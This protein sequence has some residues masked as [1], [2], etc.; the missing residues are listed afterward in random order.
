MAKP[1]SRRAPSGGTSATSSNVLAAPTW[2]DMRQVFYPTPRLDRISSEV[3]EVMQSAYLACKPCTRVECKRVFHVVSA[4]EAAQL[5]RRAQLI[6][7]S[8]PLS[9]ACVGISGNGK[10]LAT[11]FIF[12]RKRESG[13]GSKEE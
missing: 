4:T 7:A 1:K 13:S 8:V 3:L 10:T 2:G 9:L 12:G 6:R 11:R 5:N